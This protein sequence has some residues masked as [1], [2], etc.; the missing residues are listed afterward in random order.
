VRPFTK[1][2]L[3]VLF[4]MLMGAAVYQLT[5]ASRSQDPYPGPVPGT[6]YPGLSATP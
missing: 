1:I 5:I 2:T 6:P 3:M 4:V